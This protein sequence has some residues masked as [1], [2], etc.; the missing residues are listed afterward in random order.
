MNPIKEAI[1]VLGV[2]QKEFAERLGVSAPFI[3]QI[4]SGLRRVPPELCQDIEDM[5]GGKV[6]CQAL[7]PDVFRA[8]KAA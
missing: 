6:T 5:T 1:S 8:P 3:S 4:A 2:T 7:R